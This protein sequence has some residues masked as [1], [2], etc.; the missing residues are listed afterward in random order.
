M[1]SP[2]R[3]PLPFS[4]SSACAGKNQGFE[5]GAGHRPP[6]SGDDRGGGS[7]RPGGADD[8][9]REI[10]FA[11]IFGLYVLSNDFSAGELTLLARVEP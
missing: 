5:G 1:K 10:A 9:V 8:G 11:Q 7:C 2:S 3:P 4:S 6:T